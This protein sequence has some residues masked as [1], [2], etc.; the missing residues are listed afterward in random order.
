MTPWK[1]QRNG[2][3]R[4]RE[5]QLPCYSLQMNL[6]FLSPTN[7]MSV[8]IIINDHLVSFDDWSIQP[9]YSIPVFYEEEDFHR[10]VARLE[11]EERRRKPC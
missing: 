10:E 9:P 4:S 1:A 8:R 11:A 6:L 3:K 2:G 5:D 7:R